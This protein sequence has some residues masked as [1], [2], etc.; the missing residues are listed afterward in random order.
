MAYSVEWNY[1][2]T[3][4]EDFI[5]TI[6]FVEPSKD[7]FDTYST[8]YAKILLAAASE[9]DTILK[10]LCKVIDPSCKKR[11][12]QSYREFLAKKHEAPLYAAKAKILQYNLS[13]A[14][15]ANYE[16]KSPKPLIDGRPTTK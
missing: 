9:T 15:W 6:P 7:N 8:Q 1:F 16:F 10:R 2:L 13:S 4:E 3:I 14:P 12:E 11:S 5:K